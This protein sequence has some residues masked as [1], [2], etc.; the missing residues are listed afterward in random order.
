[1]EILRQFYF[2]LDIEKGHLI[3]IGIYSTIDNVGLK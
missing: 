2:F 1:M 3:N